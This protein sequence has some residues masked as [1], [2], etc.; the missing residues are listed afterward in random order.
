MRIFS[1][2]DADMDGSRR[3]NRRALWVF[4]ELALDFPRET[5]ELHDP[6]ADFARAV[7]H[8]RHKQDHFS[9]PSPTFHNRSADFRVDDE[10]NAFA[11][12]HL[13]ARDAHFHDDGVDY[14]WGE[15]DF[16]RAF[17]DHCKQVSY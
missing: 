16:E 13:P 3:D 6:A 5:M 10:Q 8:Y 4:A 12:A 11:G 9:L 7:P 2:S 17:C 14:D 1:A 15:W